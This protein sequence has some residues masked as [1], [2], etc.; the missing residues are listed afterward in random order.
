MLEKLSYQTQPKGQTSKK[1]TSSNN[2]AQVCQHQKNIAL[3][4]EE[5]QERLVQA[6]NELVEVLRDERGIFIK[7]I[8]LMDGI[9]KLESK[10]ISQ[11]RN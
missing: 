3:S 9:S 8:R 2:T 11:F 7:K 4:F 10:K 5:I 1:S 6:N